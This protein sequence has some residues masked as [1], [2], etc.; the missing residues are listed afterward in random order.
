MKTEKAPL[1]PWKAPFG[2][3]FEDAVGEAC[4]SAAATRV[5]RQLALAAST[6]RAIAPRHLEYRAAARKKPPLRQM[7]ADEICLGRTRK[8]VAVGSNL[9]TGE[10]RWFGAQRK[11]ETLNGFF[12]RDLSA[13]QPSAV[14]AACVDL[15]EPFRR[16]IAERL[17][18]CRIVYGKFYI[19]QHSGHAIEEA[20]R[21]KQQR[22]ARFAL[23][24][25]LPAS[26]TTP[27]PRFRWARARLST[28]ISKPCSSAVRGYRNLNYPPLKAQRLAAA[29]T[30]LVAIQEAASN[31]YF[32]RFSSRS[33]IQA[34]SAFTCVS[35]MFYPL[36]RVCGEGC[37]TG[38]IGPVRTE[39]AGP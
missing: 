8:F 2:K 15:W 39:E 29:R 28:D 20:R 33:E 23:N 31:G 11:K 19:R 24:R 1:L 10:P 30:V 14:V 32:H 37:R 6:V 7:S 21:E 3:H 5:A 9:A 13:F 26:A 12:N 35:A 22:N 34:K 38:S 18:G 36:R 27:G 17:P 25:R 4:K 16:S